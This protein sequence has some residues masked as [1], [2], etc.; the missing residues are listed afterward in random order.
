M[1]NK[2]R[3]GAN[4]W[5]T[6]QPASEPKA[7]QKPQR[8]G[9]GALSKKQPSTTQSSS[10]K[11]TPNAFEAAQQKHMEAAKRVTAGY[12]SSSDEEEL[13]TDKLLASVLTGYGGDQS[14]L[15]RTQ[16]CLETMFQ[17]GAATCLICIASIRRVDYVGKLIR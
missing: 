10:V 14:A 3:N 9:T 8:G 12:E 13:E 4:P 16:Q 15:S 1:S 6:N 2:N 11:P 5:G 7:K 17:S